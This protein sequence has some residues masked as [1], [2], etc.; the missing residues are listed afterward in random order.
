VPS[1]MDH[2]HP[3]AFFVRGPSPLARLTFFAALSI[4]LM[5]VDARL[6]YLTEIR[7][8]VSVVL[9][10]LEVAVRAPVNAFL[11]VS[12]YI[13]TQTS[14]VHENRQLRQR[15]LQ[16]SMELQRFQTLQSENAHLRN[17]LSALPAMP[18]PARLGE[19]VHSGRDPF[20]QKVVVNL[21][22]RHGITSGQAVIDELG[23]IGQVTQVYPFS[24]EV[25]LV[26]D[27]DLAIPVQVERS[28][29]RA[30]AFGNSR[31]AAIDLPYL[32]V[33]VDIQEGDKLVTSGIDGVYPAG[34]AVATVTHI[35]RQSF[36]PFARI[37]CLPTAGIQTHRQVLLVPAA[38]NVPPPPPVPDKKSEK[39]PNAPRKP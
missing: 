4:V 1:S 16:N 20:S 29:L 32:P 19:I 3:P 37:T 14:L 38:E 34:L 11:Y 28:G 39:T 2:H 23:V 13:T 33:N 18:Q 9:H 25:T 24:S 22:A 21:G 17:L 6:H 10:P 15:A 31:S 35:D 36:A 30:I 26:T 8:G 27:K 5:A 7:Q 12:D